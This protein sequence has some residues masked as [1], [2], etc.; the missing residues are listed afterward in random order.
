MIRP[1]A[2]GNM[3]LP[4]RHNLPV[5]AASH[6][7]HRVSEDELWF[8]IE[9]GPLT[10][11]KD[12]GIERVPLPKRKGRTAQRVP[13]PDRRLSR[14]SSKLYVDGAASTRLTASRSTWASA[15]KP[16]GLWGGD[17]REPGDRLGRPRHHPREPG[18]ALGVFT[19]KHRDCHRT[20]RPA[21]T[22]HRRFL[23]DGH[24]CPS[25]AT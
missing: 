14:S 24:L 18:N 6:K 17:R 7:G 22:Q 8:C 3:T 16:G 12:C 21:V 11:P 5:T 13:G 10:N 1:H 20:S 9:D 4:R 15:G 23:R 19:R 25:C 2:P